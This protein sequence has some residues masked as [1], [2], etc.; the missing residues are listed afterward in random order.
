MGPA[1]T[2]RLNSS[3]LEGLS[4]WIIASGTPGLL[5]SENAYPV[6]P[7]QSTP[8]TVAVVL[9]TINPKP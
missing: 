4:D 8:I 9:Y 6:S 7:V 5:S 3:A 2:E 1:K